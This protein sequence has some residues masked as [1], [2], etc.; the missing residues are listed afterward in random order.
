MAGVGCVESAV[1]SIAAV[2]R[3]TGLSKD[4]LRVWERRYGFP[5]PQRD[6]TGER[7]YPPEQVERLRLIR[8]LIDAGHRPGKLFGLAP[9]ELLE[10][11]RGSSETEVDPGRYQPLIDLLKTQ[12]VADFRAELGQAALRLGLERF[13]T[14]LCAPL[15]IAVGE[16]WAGG[17][18][19]IFEE[20][21]YTDVMQSVLRTAIA[22]I[23]VAPTR[24]V[25]LLST[26]PGEPHGLGLLMA[27]ALLTLG[28]AQCL[29]LGTQTPLGEIDLAARRSGV[30][31]VA[32]S[33]SA[34]MSPG[35]VA[36]GLAELRA[37]LPQT[38]E[39]W[40]GGRSAGLRRKTADGLFV[41]PSLQSIDPALHR[42]RAQHLSG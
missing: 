31:I 39:I 17:R 37:S 3:D 16:A 12:R 30:D 5:V 23:P 10:L 28:G 8:R 2:E 9:P 36:T 1:L 27:Q 14:D 19:D 32:L 7:V 22:G 40:A 21:L 38:V 41:L 25:V 24:P 29:S 13:V 33:F 20:H 42:W 18:M 26:F 15:T 4:T 6:A 11:S 35:H 34:C